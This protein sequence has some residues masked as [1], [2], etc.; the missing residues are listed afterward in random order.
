MVGGT[1][2]DT[3]TQ[4]GKGGVVTPGIRE[5]PP[6]ASAFETIYQQHLSLRDADRYPDVITNCGV[7][8][9]YPPAS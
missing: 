6:Y 5:H 8:V 2:F 7:P 4:T 3:A 1:V 9:G